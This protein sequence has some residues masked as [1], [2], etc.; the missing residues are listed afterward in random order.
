MSSDLSSIE[1]QFNLNSV[2]P[3]FESI[4]EF[5]DV[6]LDAARLMLY[7]REESINLAPKVVE[8]LLALVERG[9]EIVSKEEMMNRL[10]K[11]SFVE[12]SNLTQ[13]IYLLRK[14]LGKTADGRELIETFRRRGYRF[15]GEVRVSENQSDGDLRY[16]SPPRRVDDADE[17]KK[18]DTEN[19]GQ[20]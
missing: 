19:I 2:K 20:R 9:G 1:S 4:Y 18:S 16:I 8:T 10:W 13:N 6:R 7:R 17:I 11:N 14:T 3:N 15:N 5:E 12:E